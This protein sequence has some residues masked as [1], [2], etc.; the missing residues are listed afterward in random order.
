M[1][2]LSKAKKTGN[3]GGLFTAVSDKSSRPRLYTDK[4]I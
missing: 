2:A 3:G 1:G 4:G